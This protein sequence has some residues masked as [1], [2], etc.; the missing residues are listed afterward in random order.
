MMR[1]QKPAANP[2]AYVAK[3]KG[4]RRELVESLRAAVRGAARLDEQIKWGHIVYFSNGPV[5]LIRAEPRRVLFGFWR[6]KRL[7]D[8]EPWLKGSG[9]YELRTVEL[10]EGDTV[11]AAV[12]RKL[13]KTA[14]AL[15]RT[16]G[17]P[18][19]AAR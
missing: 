8:I 5:L 3:L 14:V 12:A 16:V 13:T 1:K 7:T 6:G 4:W 19:A 18:A 11:S 2:D 9:K 10:R 17:N 15:N